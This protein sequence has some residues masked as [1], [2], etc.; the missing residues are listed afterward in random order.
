MGG[1]T[2]MRRTTERERSGHD[3]ERAESDVR[4]L[5]PA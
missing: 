4:P 3:G 1:W 5:L 2:T